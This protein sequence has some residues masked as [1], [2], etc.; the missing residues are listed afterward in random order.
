MTL[1]NAVIYDSDKGVRYEDGVDNLHIYNA[2]FGREL[3]EQFES[4]GGYGSGFQVKNCLF[5]S[6]SKPDEASDDS[7]MAVDTA[8]FVSSSSDNYHL[9]T[10]SPAI[11]QGVTIAEVT[12]DRDGLT[13]PAGDAYD[14]GAYESEGDGPIP[15]DSPCDVETHGNIDLCTVI[16]TLRICSGLTVD[17]KY[18]MDIN[19]DGKINMTDAIYALQAYAELRD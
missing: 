4:A 11:D 9:A 14:I 15:S 2:T 3:A 16:N 12:T 18:L 8:A 17:K 1:K 6:A 19:G 10:G 5:L 7:N 13:R